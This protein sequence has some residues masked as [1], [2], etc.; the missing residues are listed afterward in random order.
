GRRPATAAPPR[1]SRVRGPGRLVG[2]PPA[3][4]PGDLRVDPNPAAR[5]S[6]THPGIPQ[7]GRPGA[8][9]PAVAPAA[10]LLQPP[11]PPPRPGHHPVP[12]AGRGRGSDR[13][14]AAP[15]GGMSPP[16]EP[17]ECAFAVAIPFYS[18]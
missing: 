3:A 4:G 11:G 1:R 17:L 14:A 12:P 6:G 8:P 13:P 16:G 10:A 2:S 5:R 18:P 7:H 15:A 9:A